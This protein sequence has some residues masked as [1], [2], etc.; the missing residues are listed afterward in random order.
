MDVNRFFATSIAGIFA[1]SQLSDT[2]ACALVPPVG[3]SVHIAEESA[4]IIWDAST[5]TQHFIRRAL[6]DT[7]AKDFES[8]QLGLAMVTPAIADRLRRDRLIQ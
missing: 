3:E 6:F 2:R 1:L 5:K 8:N 7:K 4:L